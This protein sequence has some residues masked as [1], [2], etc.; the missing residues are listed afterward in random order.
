MRCVA[1]IAIFVCLA[2]AKTVKITWKDCGDSSYHGKVNKIDISP[3]PPVLGQPI[4]VV[5]DGSI[6]E[7]VTAGQYELKIKKI[8]TVLDHKDNICGDSTIKLPLGMG[9]ITVKGLTCPQKAG[10]VKLGQDMTISSNAPSGT[11]GIDLTAKDAKGNNLVCVAVTAV[12]SDSTEANE[13]SPLAVEEKMATPAM[14][15]TFDNSTLGAMANIQP[16]RKC[17]FD[18]PFQPAGCQKDEV[19][20]TVTGVKGS[21]C[22]P[23]C[24]NSAC[25]TDVCPGTVATPQCVLSMGKSGRKFCA[26]TVKSCDGTGVKCSSDEHMD[27]QPVQ[28]IG[29]CTYYS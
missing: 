5:A 21:F 28:G 6:N 17:H 4:H 26:L 22:A 7:D 9:S 25:P 13:V 20:V 27:C 1:L 10:D 18:D 16:V 14:E 3:N 12:V 11:I 15:V 8:I 2:S 19:N 29:L 24:T 23:E